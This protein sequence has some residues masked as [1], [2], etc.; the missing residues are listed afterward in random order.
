LNFSKMW[1]SRMMSKSEIDWKCDWCNDLQWTWKS[2]QKYLITTI[3]LGVRKQLYDIAVLESEVMNSLLHE[4]Q[5]YLIW[6]LK[7]AM[8]PFMYHT[9][10]HLVVAL[11]TCESS[12]YKLLKYSC[13]T[14]SWSTRLLLYIYKRFGC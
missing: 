10:L 3:D 6:H 12:C 7:L 8:L 1:L 2:T 9:D 11:R 4:I 5:A 14:W 13:S